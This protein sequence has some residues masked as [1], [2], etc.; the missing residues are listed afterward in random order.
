MNYSPK[1]IETALKKAFRRN[2]K[3]DYDIANGKGFYA[4]A[5]EEDKRS[6]HD[7]CIGYGAALC[8]IKASLGLEFNWFDYD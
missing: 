7:Y 6:D 2:E 5:S 3:R 1:E 8:D 4:T